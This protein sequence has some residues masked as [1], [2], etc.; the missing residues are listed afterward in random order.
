MRVKLGSDA[1]ANTEGYGIGVDEGGHLVEFMADWVDL[2]AL[3]P[4]GGTKAVYL[5]VADW[6][7]IAIEDQPRNACTREDLDPAQRASQRRR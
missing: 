5:E 4:P 3:E 1:F 2:D 7:V 6:A